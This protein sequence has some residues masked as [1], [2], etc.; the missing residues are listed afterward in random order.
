MNTSGGASR[1]GRCDRGVVWG[2]AVG[3]AL[4]AGG[5]YTMLS[6]PGAGDTVAANE[7]YSAEC[8]RCHGATGAVET[9]V[10]PWVDYL[11]ASQVGW[12]N[13]YGSPHWLDWHWVRVRP[14]TTSS[15]QGSG[16]RAAWGRVPS[17]RGG[18]EGDVAI[19]R[20]GAGTPTAIPGP[21]P[22]SSPVPVVA[23]PTPQPTP[24]P[25]PKVEEEEEKPKTLPESG[26][27]LRR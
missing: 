15:A 2:L 10:T 24:P 16:G 3:L 5:C 6:H 20:S 17:R 23:G 9:G 11:R 4:A 26:R 25:A 1:A 13:Y 19:W 27:G 12:I 7:G 18:T 21:I 14:D 22:G 8:L